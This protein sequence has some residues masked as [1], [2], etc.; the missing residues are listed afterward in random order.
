MYK[1]PIFEDLPCGSEFFIQLSYPPVYQRAAWTQPLT[2]ITDPVPPQVIV[3]DGLP[4]LRSNWSSTQ[5]SAQTTSTPP[6]PPV[7][8]TIRSRPLS[9]GATRTGLQ[10]SQTAQPTLGSQQRGNFR[11][12]PLIELALV[13]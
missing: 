8:A 12:S 5:Q 3:H 2:V 10:R 4:H 7:S 1:L 9:A 6:H 11:R 13:L